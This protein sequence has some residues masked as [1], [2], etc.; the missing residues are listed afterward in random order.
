M[1]EFK[2]EQKTLEIGKVKVGGFP[3]ENPTVLVG[4]IFYA[5]HK[6]VYDERRGE[7]D[8]EK[9]GRLIENQ[10]RYSD[11]TGN[12][13]MIDLVASTAEA[14][15]KY[16]DF[17]AEKTDSPILIDSPSAEVRTAGLKYASEIGLTER[18]IY[19]SII[20]EIGEDEIQTLKSLGVKNAVILTYTPRDF[21][22]TGR[23]KAAES[24]IEKAKQI[25]IE[26][27]LIDTCVLDV[28]SLGAACG[29]LFR[30]KDRFG[31]P[32][33]CGAHNAVDTWR[34]LKT[35]FGEK[36]RVPALVS[37]NVAPIVL[38]ADFILYGPIEHADYVFPA[39]AM[40]DAAYAF[41]LREKGVKVGRDHPIYRIA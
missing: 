1:F 39:V 14:M 30:L 31:L 4:T 35:K 18:V 16:M 17:V 21:T 6:I 2:A 28:L 29:A 10:E 37:A 23:V 8:R 20:P 3:G 13:C 38:G 12:P 41:L 7:F 15:K 9:A 26:N 40:L 5:K 34:G 27:I 25:G 24:L 11:L 22:S 36:A 19:N 32:V 33:G